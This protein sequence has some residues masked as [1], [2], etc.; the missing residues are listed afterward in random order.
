MVN[1]YLEKNTLELKALRESAVSD[2]AIASTKVVMIDAAL[3]VRFSKLM[4]NRYEVQNKQFGIVKLTTPEGFTVK[5]DV[6]KTVKWDSKTLQTIA[7]KL[8]WS[9]VES[10]FDIAFKIT[11]KNYKE[12]SDD[13]MVKIDAARTVVY[14]DPKITIED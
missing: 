2:K 11:E 10:I 13:L 6:K 9:E 4:L 12:L 7:S 3:E 14:A 1:K 8:K 5:S